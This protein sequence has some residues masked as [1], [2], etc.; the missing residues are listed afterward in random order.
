MTKEGFSRCGVRRGRTERSCSL[1][2][3]KVEQ[4]SA[5]HAVKRSGTHL[6]AEGVEELDRI[7]L[8]DGV[9]RA[10]SSLQIGENVVREELDDID[11]GVGGS[12]TLLQSRSARGNRSEEEDG[13]VLALP[14]GRGVGGVLL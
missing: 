6:V 1:V 2:S 13:R 12:D 8:D 14:V 10:G 3:C 9:H 5:L 11:E 7:S 4:R